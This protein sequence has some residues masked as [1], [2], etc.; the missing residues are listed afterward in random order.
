MCYKL[1]L[2]KCQPFIINYVSKR[3]Y[4]HS[5][6]LDI[7]QE[8]NRVA[9]EKQNE[10]IEEKSSKPDLFKRWIYGICRF[11]ILAFFTSNKRNRITYSDDIYSFYCPQDP[12]PTPSSSLINKEFLKE[13]DDWLTPLSNREKQVL[14]LLKKGHK[15]IEISKMLS[16][17]PA[18]V[19]VY[20][21]AGIAKIKSNNSF[22]EA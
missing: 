22:I 10:Y 14:D 11:Q 5:N 7:I 20:R 15:Q 3:I 16:I 6:R 21:K 1:E 8:I 18:N 2:V 12:S 9:L 19:S 13:F 4:N 17:N